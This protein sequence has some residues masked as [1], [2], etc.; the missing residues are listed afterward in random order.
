MWVLIIEKAWAKLH[1]GYGFIDGGL[2]KE[3]LHDLTGAPAITYYVEEDNKK[4]LEV[5]WGRIKEGEEKNFIMCTGSTDGDDS[6]AEK[7]IHLGHSYS[8]LEAVEIDL[9]HRT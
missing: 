6:E 4:A 9:N 1:K 7:G 2:A 8:L 5:V 3:A